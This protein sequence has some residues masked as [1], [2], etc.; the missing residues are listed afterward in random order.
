[1][2]VVAIRVLS[3]SGFADGKFGFQMNGAPNAVWIVEAADNGNLAT[4][5]EIGRVTLDGSGVP[6]SVSSDPGQTY[7]PSLTVQGG[8]VTDNASDTMPGARIYRIRMA[9]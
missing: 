5:T 2:S 6:T 3:N 8:R 9:P 4:W 7:T 1:M